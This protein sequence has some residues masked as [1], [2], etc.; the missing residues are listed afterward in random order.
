MLPA[1]AGL[2]CAD[3]AAK[4]GSAAAQQPGRKTVIMGRIK[5][6]ILRSEFSA[7]TDRVEAALARRDSDANAQEFLNLM[8]CA[9]AEPEPVF[10]RD[11]EAIGQD[12]VEAGRGWIISWAAPEKKGTPLNVRFT[13]LIVTPDGSFRN[14][15]AGT[16]EPLPYGAEPSAFMEALGIGS[17][18]LRLGDPAPAPDLRPGTAL[19]SL[20]ACARRYLDLA[21]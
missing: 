2:P 14:F 11:P 19:K 9:G 5:D 13:G 20:A 21:P 7:E 16:A 8:Y 4:I 15:E 17:Y 6:E 1:R 10:V 12:Y 18:M 3:F